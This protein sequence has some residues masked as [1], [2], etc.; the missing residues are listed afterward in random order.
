MISETEFA[1]LFSAIEEGEAKRAARMPTE[2][3]ALREMFTAWQRLKD[4]GWKEAI[5][6]QKDGTEFLAI[7]AGSTGI[8]SCTYSG[9]WPDGHWWIHDGDIWP[10]RPILWRPRSILDANAGNTLRF[11]HGSE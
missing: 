5:Y 11:Q 3:D 4:L 1:H 6:C 2:A 9:K 10:S 8:H 7:E